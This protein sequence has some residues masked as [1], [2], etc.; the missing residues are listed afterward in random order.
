MN[1]DIRDP[2]VIGAF[3]RTIL[4]KYNFFVFFFLHQ[5][6]KI[7]QT[8]T[9]TGSSPFVTGESFVSTVI[10]FSSISILTNK[11]YV[12][13]AMII[14][15]QQKKLQIKKIIV[16]A[17]NFP[18]LCLR[19]RDWDLFQYKQFVCKFVVCRPFANYKYITVVK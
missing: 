6:P 15:R 16:S 11:T 9:W 13:S 19:L 17:S 14:K 18:T 5:P 2:H 7:Y 10:F 1:P 12:L 8:H 3:C 4:Q